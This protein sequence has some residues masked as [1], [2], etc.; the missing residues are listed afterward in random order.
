MI[1]ASPQPNIEDEPLTVFTPTFWCLVLITGAATGLA[2]GLLMKLL[3]LVQHLAWHYHEGDFFHATEAVAPLWRVVVLAGAGLVAAIVLIGLGAVKA[4]PGTSDLEATIWFHD[5][6]LPPI[7][8]TIKA[9]LSI[10]IVGLGASLGREAAP[11]QMGALFGWLFA[12]WAGIAASRQRLLAAC[13]AGAGI[14]AVYNVPLGGALFTLEVLL[15]T[16]A[17]PLVAPACVATLT[18]T[19]VYWLVMGNEPTYQVPVMPVTP[20]LLAFAVVFAPIAGV[21]SSIFVKMIA[22][23]ARLRPKG[24]KIFPATLVVFVCVG[25]VATAYP[26]ILGNGKG[27][28]ERA[29]LNQLALPTLAALLVLKP[30]ATAACLGTGAPGGLFTPSVAYGALLGGVAGHLW[31]MVWPDAPAGAFALIGAAAVLAATT[32]GPISAIVLFLELTGHVDGLVV[33]LLFATSIAT[34][35]AHRIDPR[36][37]YTSRLPGSVTAI[38]RA[39]LATVEHGESGPSISA[40]TR[41]EA[42]LTLFS[43]HV[44]ILRVDVTDDDGS[45]IGRLSRADV[46]SPPLT[47]R[48][49]EIATAVDFLT[50]APDRSQASPLR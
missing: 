24:W 33:P 48:P 14:A 45:T 31:M 12:G 16:L 27:V 6:R 50:C 30:L 4:P 42:I 15:G 22:G 44:D 26:Q 40:A 46:I 49:L 34:I 38:T 36:S 19:A 5:G 20:G 17:L 2:A 47:A 39:A 21:A 10:V 13:G 32:K 1:D 28:I 23:V 7:R 11:K 35:V 29:A 41:Y 8:T 25:L 43:R 37:T 9:L 3:R 18:A